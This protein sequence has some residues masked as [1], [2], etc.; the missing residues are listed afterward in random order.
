M[1]VSWKWIKQLV[2]LDVPAEEFERRLMLAGLN[3]EETHAVG[4]DL[5]IDLE[6]TSNRPDCLGHVGIAREASVVF[7]VPL[8]VP[9]PQPST[10]KTPVA[11]L[12]KVAIDCPQLCT[13]YTARV[14]QGVK[15][16]PSPKW[17]IERLATLGIAAI[18]NVVDITNYVLME[19]GQPLH[20]FDFRKLE[21][22]EIMVREARQG[23]RFEAINHKTYELAPGMCVIADRA[24][25]VALGGVMGGADTEVNSGTVDVLIEA[26]EFDPLSIRNTARKL[27]LHSDSSYRFERG[28]DPEGVDWASRRCCELILQEAGGELASDVV[29]VG[30]QPPRR[31]P[32]ILRL[33][34]LKR[35]LG[36]DVDAV[37]VR[38]ILT[39]LGNRDVEGSRGEG[40]GVSEAKQ[41]T[42]ENGS[43][44]IEMIPPSWRRDLSRE[45][46]LIEEVARIHGYDA[47]PEDV[48]VPMAA[49]HRTQRDR[50]LSKIREVLVSAGVDEAMTISLVEPKVAEAFSPWTNAASLESSTPVLRRADRLRTSLIPS[51]LEARR[52][53]EAIGNH[54]IELFEIARIYLPVKDG[55]PDEQLM[56][57]F[58]SGGDFLAAKGIVEAIVA[59]LNPAQSVDVADFQHP[60]F[61]LGRA[62]ELKLAGKRIGFLG[63][64]SAKALKSFELRQPTTVAELEIGALERFYQPIP[65]AVE[66]SMYPSV[67][68]DLNLVVAEPIR[69]AKL[70][71]TVRSAA[72]A[73]LESIEFRDTYRD[74]QRLGAGKKSQL[75]SIV[76]R[77]KDG[78]L[79]NTE[80]DQ[81]R[82]Q[83]VAACQREHGAELRI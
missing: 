81:V 56:L 72:G 76:L 52:N 71:A 65:R 73:A 26:A 1:I 58:T 13:R 41:R 63:E 54:R 18:N 67:S 68:R 16:K 49:S 3:H 25:A 55:L 43:Q 2:P 35:I 40:R 24:R 15:V 50:V 6:I 17:L 47:I 42:S 60:L 69:W 44:T 37:E 51:L 59:R 46:D 5:A 61:K 31:E 62:C 22:R 36:I 23:E 10:G 30:R 70:A 21:G 82:D 83:I 14:I 66:L 19:S 20:A 64:V 79:T 34:Q 53:N 77:R 33:S 12:T 8:A 27:S 28:L 11:E 7:R 4:D 38:R 75:F 78:T 39:A 9:D 32:I 48:N 45:I 80:A 57:S 29:D 74:P